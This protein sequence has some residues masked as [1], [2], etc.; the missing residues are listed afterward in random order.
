MKYHDDGKLSLR[1][2]GN[3]ESLIMYYSIVS[4]FRSQCC[5]LSVD[6]ECKYVR[7]VCVCL[8]V[9]VHMHVCMYI[10]TCKHVHAPFFSCPFHRFGQLYHCLCQFHNYVE[11]EVRIK[12]RI[13]VLQKHVKTIANL[14]LYIFCSSLTLTV[15][16][17]VPSDWE[18]E[19]VNFLLYM[20]TK[21]NFE[22][23]ILLLF[24][25]YI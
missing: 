10:E 15:P 12:L 2:F 8:C 4:I 20:Y 13:S 24:N 21:T 1:K 9:C 17:S 18:C 19:T 23:V 6:W 3:K 7:V 11:I 5:I 25:W 14:L 16:S 22:L